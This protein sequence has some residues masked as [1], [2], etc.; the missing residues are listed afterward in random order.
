MQLNYPIT[1]PPRI[2]S[3]S[4]TYI[5]VQVMVTER[6]DEGLLLLG[7]ML[8]WELIDLTYVVV[9]ETK[10]GNKAINGVSFVNPPDFEDLPQEAR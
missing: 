7:Q 5:Y 9:N 2:P 4:R 8:R 10:E 3:L 6:F 1:K